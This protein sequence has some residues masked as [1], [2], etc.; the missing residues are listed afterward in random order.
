MKRLL[1]VYLL[2]IFKQKSFYI[3]LAIDLFLSVIIGIIASKFSDQPGPTVG[4]NLPGIFTVTIIPAIYITIFATSDFTD[5]ATKNFIARGYTRRQ[6]LYGKYLA[7]IIAIFT[8][9]IVEGIVHTLGYMGNGFGFDEIFVIKMVGAIISSFAAIG[10]YVIV[11]NTLEKLS[12]AM[13]FNIIL[14]SFFP[15][16]SSILN[17]L[18]KIDFNIQGYWVTSLFSII[19][20]TNAGIIDLLKVLGLTVGYLIIL[21]ELSNFIIKRKEVK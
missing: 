17:S 9:F 7:S 15:M 3:C 14:L 8:F 12:M 11:S 20:E 1:K 13:T 16:V 10:F 18:L 5:G 19:P 21:F 6:L 2:N 4:A